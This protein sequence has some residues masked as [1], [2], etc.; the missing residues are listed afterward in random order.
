MGHLHSRSGQC[1]RRRVGCPGCELTIIFYTHFSMQAFPKEKICSALKSVFDL[2]VMSFAG[3]QMGAVN[4]MRP[5]GVPD[6]S[7]VQSDEVWVGVVYGLAATM[8]HEVIEPQIVSPG[9][10]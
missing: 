5:E 9:S 1:S 3:G 2:N 6:H 8:I 10:R 7:S 4:G